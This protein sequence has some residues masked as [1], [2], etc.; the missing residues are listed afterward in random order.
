MVSNKQTVHPYEQLDVTELESKVSYRLYSQMVK[1]FLKYGPE[2]LFRFPDHIVAYFLKKQ[3]S[4]Y[5]AWPDGVNF[6]TQLYTQLKKRYPT[7]NPNVKRRFI[8][9]LFGNTFTLSGYRHQRVEEELGTWPCLMVLS[10][11]MRC[12]LKCIGCYSAHYNQQDVMDTET[13]DRILTEAEKMGIYFVVVSGGEPF[14]RKDILDLFAAHPDILFMTYTNSVIIH[15]KNLVPRMADL[16]NVMPAI[17]VEGFKKETDHRRGEGV[18]N[19]IISVMKQLKEAGVLFGFSAT[20]MRFN[21]DL[22]VSDEFLEFYQELGAFFGWYFSYMPVGRNPDLSLMPTPKQR[23]HRYHRVRELRQ[24][25]EVLVSDF[26]CDGPL[27]GGCLSSGR[28]YFH[29]NSEGGVEPCVFHQF[30]VDNVLEKSLMEALNSDYFQYMRKRLAEVDNPLRPC[31][32]IDQPQIL[33]DAYKTFKPK[34]SQQGGDQIITELSHGLDDYSKELAEVFD[35][36]WDKDKPINYGIA[37]KRTANNG[38]GKHR[39]AD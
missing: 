5:I 6:V 27:V 8:Q 26:W 25:Y 4:N 22:L 15:D 39:K 35:P 14:M 7:I 30:H 37:A 28:Q 1:S 33:R 34:I 11:T 24:K 13:V 19:K 21:N 2:I 38:N 36:I 3:I 18:Y 20:P 9:N 16:G 17:S 32:V 12:N 23:E 31:P 29:V 10:P